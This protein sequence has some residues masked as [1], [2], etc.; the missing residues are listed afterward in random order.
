MCRCRPCQKPGSGRTRWPARQCRYQPSL[1]SWSRWKTGRWRCPARWDPPGSWCG[2]TQLH[3]E[4]RLQGSIDFNSPQLLTVLL[5]HFYLLACK[6]LFAWKLKYSLHFPS[7]FGTD[8]PYGRLKF[9]AINRFW[10][11]ATASTRKLLMS[12]FLSLSDPCHL[13]LLLFS[14]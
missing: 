11:V 14:C 3:P 4:A 13:G 5:S 12:E 9:T 8:S 1:W 7:M 10:N 2:Q 6:F